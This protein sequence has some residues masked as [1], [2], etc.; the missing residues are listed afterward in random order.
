MSIEKILE[1]Y[2]KG[3]MSFEEASVALQEAYREQGATE[4]LATQLAAADLQATTTQGFANFAAPSTETPLSAPGSAVAPFGTS[5]FTESYLE[6]LTPEVRDFAARNFD[7]VA[8]AYTLRN[9]PQAITK[10]PGF[11]GFLEENPNVSFQAALQ[12]LD[13]PANQ[14]RFYQNQF[15]NIYNEFLGNIGGQI[16]QGKT[17][18]A[19]FNE[20]LGEFPFSERFAA[21]PPQ[22]RGDFPSNVAPRTRYL[23]GF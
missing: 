18:S 11:G 19:T 16:K 4:T 6:S 7:P 12:G 14:R 22:Q 20:F 21:T 10:T 15:S 2:R 8:T 23:Y 9:A 5:R 13:Q 17:P 1:A 3:D